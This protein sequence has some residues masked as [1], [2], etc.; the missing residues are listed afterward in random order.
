[1]HDTPSDRDLLHTFVTMKDEGAFA[2]LVR[3]HQQMMLGVAAR[4]CRNPHDAMDA[5]Q[6]ALIAFAR[7]AGE[8]RVDE[9]G[10][11]P[12]LHG[13]T[14]MEALAVRRQ[15]LK[16]SVREREAMEQ[17]QLLTGDMPEEVAGELDEAINRL[18]PKDRSAVVLHFLEN[19]TFRSIAQKHGGTEAAWQKRG[20]RALE[21]L[22]G[23]LRRRG[24]VATGTALG[25]W[26]AASPAK[27]AVPAIAIKFMLNEALHQPVVA[28][29]STQT[30]TA[31]LLIMKLKTTLVLCFVGGAILSYGLSERNASSVPAGQ[32]EITGSSLPSRTDRSRNNEPV[33]NLEQIAI[34]IRQYDSSVEDSSGA[35][36]RLRALMFSIPESYLA[37]V[38]RL[39]ED[40]GNPHR[41]DEIAA[42]FYA[43]WAEIDPKN[44]WL[45][46]LADNTYL[47]PARRG[48]LLTWLNTAP[49]TALAGLLE[50]R[51]NKDIAILE[52][53]LIGQTQH[54][55]HDAATLVDRLA[56]SWPQ[57]D[58]HLFPL[59]AKAWVQ[60]DPNAAGEWIASYWDRDL[61]NLTLNR[62]SWRVATKNGYEGLKLADLID[63]AEARRQ[64]RNGAIR[65]WGISSGGPAILP[66]V[67]DPAVDLSGGFPADWKADEIRSFSLGTMAN[68]SKYYPELVAVARDEAQKQAIYEGVIGG[69]GFSQPSL[70][71]HAVESVDQD[72]AK[73][74]EGSKSLSSFI[75]RWSET[76]AAA[77]TDWLKKQPKDPKSDLMRDALQ[78]RA[79]K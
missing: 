44:A 74:P 30:S 38:H 40:V 33:F 10:A 49:E 4:V 14:T 45:A 37:S 57:A 76:D 53:F 66:N 62:L 31:L 3:R 61:R 15:R 69:I 36:S 24:V 32:E 64:A 68:Y 42:C 48:V 23:M 79:G 63:D 17:Q 65:W 12:W 11:G 77:A 71:A 26:L 16:R 72:F 54:A 73:T 39:L 60:I 59:V 70:A 1:M 2:E 58:R 41:F 35:E 51:T 13:A 78:S 8:I 22:S 67:G 9:A 75:L 6:R 21:K 46:A 20:V 56:E 29:V 18:S 55:P 25:A 7:R 27:A 52:E 47:L 34:A 43:R 50:H 28:G 19:H 5:M